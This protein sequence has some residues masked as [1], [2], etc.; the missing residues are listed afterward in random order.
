MLPVRISPLLPDTPLTA[1]DE[2]VLICWDV[3]GFSE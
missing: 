3:E 2:T 1:V